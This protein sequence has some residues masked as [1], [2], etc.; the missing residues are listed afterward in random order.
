MIASITRKN[1]RYIEIN[2]SNLPNKYIVL[3]SKIIESCYSIL[4]NVYKVNIFQDINDKK[5]I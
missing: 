1:I 3:K 2:I 4:E 5:L